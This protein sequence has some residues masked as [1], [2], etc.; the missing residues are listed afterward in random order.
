MSEKRALKPLARIRAFGDAAQEPL[1][2]ATSPALAMAT[3]LRQVKMDLS[4]IQ[5]HEINKA[6]AVVVLANMKKIGLQD[7]SRINIFGG[8]ISLGHIW[9]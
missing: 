7:T 6:F 8:A 9:E 4:D 5:C 3:A 2:F 1:N